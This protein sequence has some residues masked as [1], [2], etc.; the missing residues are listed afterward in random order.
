MKGVDKPIALAKH[1]KPGVIWKAVGLFLQTVPLN[2]Q[3][4]AELKEYFAED[5]GKLEELLQ[6]G[7]S[8]RHYR[9]SSL[10]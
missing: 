1:I 9:K 5:V 4:Q 8:C 7:L 10:V 2:P 6:C 3:I